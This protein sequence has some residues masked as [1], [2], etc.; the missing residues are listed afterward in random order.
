MY[1]GEKEPSNSPKIHGKGRFSITWEA[2]AKIINTNSYNASKDRENVSHV[3]WESKYGSFLYLN[4]QY[5][6]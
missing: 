5:F 6:L 2:G 3:E 1:K 4:E